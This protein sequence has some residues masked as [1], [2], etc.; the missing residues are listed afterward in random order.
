ME[1]YCHVFSLLRD[2]GLFEQVTG[3]NEDAFVNFN[4]GSKAGRASVDTA[5]K[6][7]S[8]SSASPCSRDVVSSPRIRGPLLLERRDAGLFRRYEHP[9]VAGRDLSRDRRKGREVGGRQQHFRAA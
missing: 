3:E 2:S 7:T 8:P 6:T 1:Q 4:D 9:A 5:R